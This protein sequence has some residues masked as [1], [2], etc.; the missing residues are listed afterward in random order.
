M[1]ICNKQLL[2]S[3]VF[4]LLVLLSS[5]LITNAQQNINLAGQVSYN[6][7]LNDIWGY[8]SN[9][10]DEY[11]LVGTIEGTSIVDVTNPSNAQKLFFVEGPNSTWRDIKVYNQHAYIVT[12]GGGGMQIV[13]LTGLP[14]SI[15][16]ST[17]AGSGVDTLHSAHNIFIDENGFAYLAG[18]SPPQVDSTQPSPQTGGTVI[19]DL[20]QNL[21]EPPV[22]GVYSKNYVHDL[23]VKNDTMWTGEI[24]KGELGVVDVTNKA[25]PQFIT[26]QQT[27]N[28]F[29][30]N[31]WLSDNGNTVFTT[32][33]RT[34]AY[35]AAY[36]VQDLN[37]ISELDRFQANPGSNSIPHNVFVKN[38]YLVASYYKDGLRIVDANRPQNL[39]E[40]G[41]FD[42][43]PLSGQG[44]S[45]C[46]G[47]FPYL[48]SGNILA[49]DI[50]Q[51]LF[52]LSPNYERAC[53]LEGK[54]TG[55]NGL[56]LNDVRVEI[57]GADQETSTDLSGNYKT[58]T[59]KAGDYYVRLYKKNCDTKILSDVSLQK[60]QVTT[61]DET[62]DCQPTSTAKDNNQSAKTEFFT[63]R[64]NK[65]NKIGIY[66]RLPSVSL[67]DNTSLIVTDM[68]GK[69]L[70]RK[71]IEQEEAQL[72]VPVAS[73]GMFIVQLQHGGQNLTRKVRVVR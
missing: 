20:Q 56:P 71:K 2:L 1:L 10:G 44:F 22:V 67:Q 47:A 64:G 43:S 25:N 29:T 32:D 73:S 49:S 35:I 55:S 5:F 53:Y 4:V 24:Y 21:L 7:D 60:G 26:S 36:D 37:N 42:T 27:P 50:G 68:Y 46:W 38:D 31:T 70:H 19:L 30:H 54:I 69:I 39:V 3:P 23:F 58:G 72:Q 11:A 65:E 13:D 16:T 14:D 40:T 48:P 66:Y 17:Y 41:Y 52:I 45:G 9:S 8:S 6:E 62:L 33:E 18:H 51:G 61:L 59:T 63:Y 15:T 12:E 28:R 34:G 57:M